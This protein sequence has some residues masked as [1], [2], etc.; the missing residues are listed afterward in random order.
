[1]AKSIRLYSLTTCAYCQAIKKM[2]NDLEIAHEFIDIDLLEDQERE[3]MIA[4]LSSVN[5]KCSFPTIVID[6]LVITGFKVQEIKEAIKVR[7]EVDD[8]YDKLRSTQETKGYFFN[9]DKEWTFNLLRGMLTNKDR[10]GYMACPCRLASG[11]REKDKDIICPCVYR[12][13][14]VEEFGACYC[15]L[16]VSPDWNEGLI[17]HPLIPERRPENKE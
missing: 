8:L 14:D 13:P 2:L 3:A 1:M 4:E 10:Y 6:E 5:P 7:T 17:P 11:N 16:Y 9:N 12:K 15:Q